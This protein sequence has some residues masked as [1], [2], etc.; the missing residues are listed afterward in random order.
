MSYNPRIKDKDLYIE[1]EMNKIVTNLNEDILINQ[2]KQEIINFIKSNLIGKRKKQYK[3][4]NELLE[5]YFK[6]DNKINKVELNKY[7]YDDS[8]DIIFY[9][10]IKDIHYKKKSLRIETENE[11]WTIEECEKL[12]KIYDNSYLKIF[13]EKDMKTK[14][15]DMFNKLEQIN[16]IY[17]TIDFNIGRNNYQYENSLKYNFCKGWKP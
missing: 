16:D 17:K 11:Y 3:K 14:F 1:N 13:N 6:S 10:N 4:T 12:L 2:Y 15:T 7:T 8:G 9:I 5:E